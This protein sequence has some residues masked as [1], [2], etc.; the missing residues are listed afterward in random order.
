MNL[1][2]P[3]HLKHLRDVQ[4][5]PGGAVSFVDENNN[6]GQIGDAAT[7]VLNAGQAR[8]TFDRNYRLNN[9]DRAIAE[10]Y[11]SDRVGPRPF[12]T[13]A[14]QSIGRRLAGGFS[15]LTSNP[16][17]ARNTTGLLAALAGGAA[18]AGLS[19]ENKIRNGLLAA[20]LA[21]GGAYALAGVSKNASARQE[22]LE[23]IRTA[24]DINRDHKPV[25]M[26]K[27]NQLGESQ[28]QSLRSALYSASGAG[29]GFVIAKF[30]GIGWLLP[31]AMGG[32]VGTYMSRPLKFNA[33]GQPMLQ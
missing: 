32:L 29:V 2:T 30:L 26:Q 19:S 13:T 5:L 31:A 24:P 16:A 1:D 22:I 17:S 33:F 27:V 20:L 12:M 6:N 11:Q 15:Q 10:Q 7:T 18:A 23:T 14:A 28:L 3:E 25:M 9:F 21:G 8:A 4:Q